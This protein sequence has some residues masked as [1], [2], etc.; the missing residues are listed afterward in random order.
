MAESYV[1]GLAVSRGEFEQMRSRLESKTGARFLLIKDR[2][3]LNASFLAAHSVRR[4]FLPHWSYIIPASV[5]ESVDCVIFHMTD[6]PFGRGGSPLQNLIVRGLTSTKVS[7]LRC[8]KELDAGPV[9]LKADLSLHGS[10]QEILSRAYEIIE[11]MILELIISDPQARPQV[12]TPTIFHRRKPEDGRLNG[13][14]SIREAYDSIRMLDA[15]GYPNAFL[16][17][18]HLRIEFRKAQFDGKR[19]TVEAAFVERP[20]IRT[21]GAPDEE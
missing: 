5:Y 8:V 11:G 4:V 3:E 9:Y 21:E 13:C 17:T 14:A 20:R 7:A 1:Y 6:L 12:G 16:E 18:D 2:S 10:A 15:D 19:L